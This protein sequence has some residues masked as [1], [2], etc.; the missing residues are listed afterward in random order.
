MNPFVRAFKTAGLIV[1]LLSAAAIGVVKRG[2]G[3]PAPE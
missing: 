1:V 3:M 2:L